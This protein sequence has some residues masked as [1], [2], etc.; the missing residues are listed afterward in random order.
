MF[1]K[2]KLY[3]IVWEGLCIKNDMIAARNEFQ[4]LKKFYQLRN[5]LF[6]RIISIKEYKIDS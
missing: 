2:K 3:E 4:A 1:R 5:T 6:V